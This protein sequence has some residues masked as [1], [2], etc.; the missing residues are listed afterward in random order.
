MVN[1]EYAKAFSQVLYVLEHMDKSLVDKIPQNVINVLKENALESTNKM[2]EYSADIKDMNINSKARSILA[3][4]YLNCLC[5][6]EEKE[7][8]IKLLQKNDEIYKDLENDKVSFDNV[9]NKDV[10]EM[11]G[12]EKENIDIAIYKKENI[13]ARL[14]SRIKKLL[15]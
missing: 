10:A 5:S 1:I 8:Y 13:F 9:F 4:L 3:I 12:V 15:K 6:P 14:L 7:E 11:N 2:M